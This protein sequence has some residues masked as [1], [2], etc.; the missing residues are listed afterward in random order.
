MKDDNVQA[1]ERKRLSEAYDELAP[2]KS[3]IRLLLNRRTMGTLLTPVPSAGATGQA[4]LNKFDAKSLEGRQA[5][6]NCG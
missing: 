5:H 3:E 1:F 4:M 6:G 2:D